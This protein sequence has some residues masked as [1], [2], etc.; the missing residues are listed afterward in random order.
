MARDGGRRVTGADVA[1]AAGVSRATVSYVINQT[2]GQTIPAQTRDR[3]LAAAKRLGYRPSMAGRALRT[4]RS[5]LVVWILPDWPIGAEVGRFIEALSREASRRGYLLT[6]VPEQEGAEAIE[7]TIRQLS[8]AAIVAI[9]AL[10]DRI[11]T[12]AEASNIP[13]A[14]T[15]DKESD[16][17]ALSS[18]HIGRL[19]VEYLAGKGHRKI[20]YLYPDDERVQSFASHRLAGATEAARA[21]G[22]S[23]LR[24]RTAP[25]D[26][27]RLGRIAAEWREQGITA[28]CAYNDD[29]ALGLL[30]GMQLAGLHAPTDLAVIGCDDVPTAA[31]SMPALTTIAN[32]IA[33]LAHELLD[34]VDL[35]LTGSDSA[36]HRDIQ[37]KVIPRESA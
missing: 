19:Q 5:D 3:V 37:S 26:R 25:V 33:A 15:Q 7:T 16:E 10:P 8:P 31:L 20:A 2:P 36:V 24:K 13:I 6:M 12:L 17:L 30:S 1:T 18:R 29:W 27:E 11:V 32:D 34:S 14:S 4:G 21:L 28:V 9:H 35:V 23:A 22:L